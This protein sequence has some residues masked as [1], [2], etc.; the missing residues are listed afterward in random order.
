MEKYQSVLS[1]CPLFAGIQAEEW[2]SMLGCLDAKILPIS[3]G[4]PV[5]LEGDPARLV[6]VVLS[7]GVQ[8]VQDD[9]YGNR[10]VL[11]ILQ[12]GDSFG[13]AF[14]CAGL[15]KLPVSV[16]AVKDGEVL[17]CGMHIS[18]YEQGN[19]FNKDGEVLLLDC[20][21]ILTLCSHA[22]RFHSL[23]IQNLLQR[24]AQK[25]LSF[26]QKVRYMSQKT[27]KDKLMTYL[28]DQAKQQQS[29]EFVIPCDRQTLADYLGVERSA[30]S[31]ELGKLKRAGWLETKG[32][33]FRLHPS[34]PVNRQ[35]EE[36]I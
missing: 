6:G 7:G 34:G 31:A 3:K 12:P 24:L 21:R 16:Y 4:E 29:P 26:T 11:S 1:H 27:T 25:N 33:W 32:S 19:I 28:L 35:N 18:P 2:Q 15:N 8:V 23:L 20:R 5:F 10:S 13:E 36:P 14:S 30:M 9:Y 17:V 22:C